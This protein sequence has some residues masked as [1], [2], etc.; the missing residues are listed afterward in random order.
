MPAPVLARAPGGKHAHAL[1]RAHA[2]ALRGACAGHLPAVDGRARI[3]VAMVATRW[4]DRA[5][6]VCG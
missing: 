4:R 1:V 2:G 5:G 3:V 6:E